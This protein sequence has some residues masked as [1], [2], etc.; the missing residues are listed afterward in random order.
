MVAKIVRK[1]LKRSKS[2]I[3]LYFDNSLFEASNNYDC[4]FPFNCKLKFSP[5][6]EETLSRA[7]NFHSGASAIDGSRVSKAKMSKMLEDRGD[8]SGKQDR[9]FKDIV[10]TAS[11]ELRRTRR[12]RNG[13]ILSSSILE[14]LWA[15]S[16]FWNGGL[17]HRWHIYSRTDTSKLNGV[18]LRVEVFFFP[19]LLLMRELMTRSF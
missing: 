8:R 14:S 9:P 17:I 5:I 11:G 2:G 7:T 3:K 6:L 15:T 4:S 16:T 18:A 13:A 12:R 19:K 10:E 1:I